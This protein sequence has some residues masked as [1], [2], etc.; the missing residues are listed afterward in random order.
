[1][2]LTLDDIVSDAARSLNEVSRNKDRWY[3]AFFYAMIDAY[4]RITGEELTDTDPDDAVKAVYAWYFDTYQK[5]GLQPGSRGSKKNVNQF[6]TAELYKF[7]TLYAESVFADCMRGGKRPEAEC[8]LHFAV[9][10]QLTPEEC[11]NLLHD[12]GYL[13]LHVKNIHH[14]AIYAILRENKGLDHNAVRNYFCFTKIREMFEDAG[15]LMSEGRAVEAVTAVE[16]NAFRDNNTNLIRNHLFEQDRLN[17][18]NYLAFVSKHRDVFDYLHSAIRKEHA[19]LI[20]VFQTLFD[21]NGKS[22]CWDGSEGN[23]SLFQFLCNFCGSY[24]RKH[25]NDNLRTII[26]KKGRHPTRE[27]MILLWL[28][29]YCFLET[30]PVSITKEYR[31]TIKQKAVSICVDGDALNVG[32]YLTG[33]EYESKYRWDFS[34]LKTHINAKLEDFGWQLLSQSSA[35]D[36]VILILSRFAIESVNNHVNLSYTDARTHV[37]SVVEDK[38]RAVDNVPAPLSAV[39]DILSKIQGAVGGYVLET[40]IYEQL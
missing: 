40:A 34:E 33:E 30:E 35:F 38:L 18:D 1:M 15:K 22:K 24:D 10:L 28:Y 19:R 31:K 32:R 23:Y 37:E 12:Y 25:F 29:E 14:L 21:T 5:A 26:E 11:D 7:D 13:P 4:N 20:D 6:T 9:A 17:A 27:I 2:M 16:A 8:I 3:K 39:F 36:N